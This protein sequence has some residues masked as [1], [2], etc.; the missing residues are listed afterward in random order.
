[1]TFENFEHKADIGVRGT[2]KTIANSFEECAKAMFSIEADISK[3][4][5]KK[6]IL[7]KVSASNIAE[8]LVEWL[9]KLLAESGIKN[10]MFSKFKVKISEEDG[11]YKLYGNAYGEKLDIRRHKAKEEVKAAT[12]SQLKV[13]K[14]KKGRW[15]S[16]CIVDV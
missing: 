4:K 14:N 10:M 8:L 5:A 16:Q 6:K 2:G 3:V 7:I 11:N 12:Y 15:I 13:E 1:M 9:N